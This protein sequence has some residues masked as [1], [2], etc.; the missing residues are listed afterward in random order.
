[1]IIDNT[2]KS[3]DYNQKNINISNSKCPKCGAKN[4]MIRHGVYFRF[5]ISFFIGCFTT[6]RLKILRVKCN[7][8][9]CTHAILPG[10]LIPYKQ[11]NYS[12]FITILEK[13]LFNQNSGYE[14]S[15][16]YKV[17]FQTIYSFI[18]TYISFE[19]EIFVTLRILKLADNLF[20]SR[21][22]KL[23]ELIKT[24]LGFNNFISKF[25]KIN[26]WPFLMTKFRIASTRSIFVDFQ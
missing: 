13:Y 20:R 10:D 17:S 8:C 1:M 23:I 15:K 2:I 18:N 21:P 11:F 5:V 14:L 7:S 6:S 24:K 9:N 4:S 19:D 22:S 25:N 16:K 26:N 3:K 12:I